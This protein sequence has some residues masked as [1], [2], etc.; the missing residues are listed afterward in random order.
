MDIDEHLVAQSLKKLLL[1][2][3]TKLRSFQLTP[4][5]QSVLDEGWSAEAEIFDKNLEFVRG[6][7]LH[8]NVQY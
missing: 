7:F 4:D 5:G 3:D 2:Q 1:T 6:Y 8:L